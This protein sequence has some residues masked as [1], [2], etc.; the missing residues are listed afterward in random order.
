MQS[1]IQQIAAD[2]KESD[3][4]GLRKRCYIFPTKRGVLHFEYALTKQFSGKTFFA[5]YLFSIQEF[6]EYLTRRKVTDPMTLLFE[7]YEVYKLHDDEGSLSTFDQFMPW[8]EILLKDFDEIDKYLVDAEKIYQTIYDHKEV[9]SLFGV[10]ET[11]IAAL[12]N[13]RSIVSS[14]E[15]TELLQNFLKIWKITGSVYQAFKKHLRKK[16]LAYEGMLYR[17]MVDL[18]KKKRDKLDFDIYFCGFNA[19]SNAEEVVFETLFEQKRGFAYWDVDQIYLQ[20]QWHEAGMFVKRYQKKWTDDRNIWLTGEMLQTPKKINIIG[21][22]Q[23]M[24]QVKIAAD[25]L[26]KTVVP[27]NL[28]KADTVIVL[29]DENLLLPTLY[30]LPKNVSQTNVTMGYP[31]FNSSLTRLIEILFDLQITKRGKKQNPSYA[32]ESITAFVKNAYFQ[33]IA[34]DKYPEYFE[35]M[36]NNR[37]KYLRLEEIKKHL[38]NDL[39]LSVFNQQKKSEEM[40]DFLLD[41]LRKVFQFFDNK[42][43]SLESALESERQDSELE[44]NENQET[45]TIAKPITEPTTA[46]ANPS[47][48]Q[49]DEIDE[50][51]FQERDFLYHFI[52]RLMDF[53]ENIEANI[54]QISISLLKKILLET[55]KT[56]KIPFTGEANKGV[57]IMGFLETRTLDFENLFILSVNEGQLPT[58]RKLNSYIPYSVRKAF[59]MPTFEENDAIY[60]YHFYR[61][62][63]KAKNVY[64][65]YDTEVKTQAG[66]SGER[67]RF[68]TQLIRLVKQKNNK[69]LIKI[70]EIKYNAPP[71]IAHPITPVIQVDKTPKV[72]QLLEAFVYRDNKNPDEITSFTP[73]SLS[74]YLD[75]S[76]RFYYKRIAGI[77][78]IEDASQFIE[79]VDL[80]QIVHETLEELYKPFVGQIVKKE[81]LEPLVDV[82]IITAHIE[83]RLKEKRFIVENSQE[84]SGRN[85]MTFNIIRQVVKTVLENDLH[86]LPFKVHFVETKASSTQ[87]NINNKIDVLLTGTIDRVDE[88]M[89][90]NDDAALRIIDYKTGKVELFNRRKEDDE[91]FVTKHFETPKYRSGFQALFYSY[92]FD[93]NHGAG[94]T[95]K[96]GIYGLKEINRGVQ[97]L[98]SRAVI[99]D[100]ILEIYKDKLK[101]TFAELFNPEVP[102]SQ[103]EDVDRCK[104]CP[105]SQI[106]NR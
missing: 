30:A 66:G 60:C 13:F 85:I 25:I 75:C 56:F 78:G 101:E 82:G 89:T 15:K 102:F 37:R 73:T 54:H 8:G 74:D 95:L 76:L 61:L 1:F 87:L 67:S 106:C 59:K 29:A 83:A 53:Q 35:W 104:Y 41:F 96:A 24:A 43:Q 26:Q 45:S 81:D 50:N 2:I 22:V 21:T 28:E 31:A 14:E 57:Q 64:L 77:K 103:T 40:L 36:S 42:I 51:L 68:I 39:L 32:T 20:N 46:I 11:A 93:K 34:Q 72:M 4:N 6:V 9:E 105:Y 70:E 69:S 17:Q 12:Q 5:P 100:E 16:K 71:P 33:T 47:I 90:D 84:L 58:E 19:L 62:L 27:E 98:N 52:N 10:D 38:E 3:L 65:I 49:L 86:E 63:Q 94:R 44:V 99:S 80:G 88:P 18:F 79:A 23:N 91:V 7:L 92:L 55:L 48:E 97:L